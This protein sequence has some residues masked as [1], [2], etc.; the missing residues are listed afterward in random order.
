MRRFHRYLVL[1]LIVGLSLALLPACGGTVTATDYAADETESVPSPDPLEGITADSRVVALSRSVGELWLL[2]G[3][4]L[5]GVTDDALDLEGL[6]EDATSIGSISHPSLEQVV[7][8][9]PDLVMLTG[10]MPSHTELRTSLT[11]AAVPVLTVDIDSFD[12]YDA[13][14]A[15]LTEVTGRSDLYEANVT[16][17]RARID[18][19]IAHAAVPD[20]GSYLAL[21]TS[22]TK[23]KV[24]KS[25]YFACDML[26]DLG[27]ANVADDDSSL[28]DLSLEAI[29]KADPDWIFVIYQGDDDEAQKAFEEAFQSHPVWSQLS[30]VKQGRVMVLPKHL[31]QYKPNARW[32]EGYSYLSQI[33]NGAWA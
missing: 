23:N 13:M 29:A 31:Y 18:D 5:V 22:A 16:K 14:M 15:V 4:Q 9:E 19:I 33:L 8:L 12:D 17:V 25:D 30:A 21:R 10:D 27:M 2:A 7:A 26:N 6:S 11:E 1:L 28:D 20:R 32:A 3:G 24:L